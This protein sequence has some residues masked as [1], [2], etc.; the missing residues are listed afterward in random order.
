MAIYMVTRKSVK[1]DKYDGR[2]LFRCN[3]NAEGLILGYTL[4]ATVK[5]ADGYAV[6]VT[7]TLD[8]NRHPLNAT[9]AATIAD[10]WTHNSGNWDKDSKRFLQQVW[11]R[12]DKFTFSQHNPI[13]GEPG[14]WYA[15]PTT[16]PCVVVKGGKRSRFTA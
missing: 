5:D 16:L 14:M 8:A 4:T 13:P 3:E 15:S 7:V 10:V 2:T 9:D 6:T 11:V 1:A 12:C